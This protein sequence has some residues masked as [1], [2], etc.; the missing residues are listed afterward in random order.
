M[1]KQPGKCYNKIVHEVVIRH[2]VGGG[3][4]SVGRGRNHVSFIFGIQSRFISCID[5]QRSRNAST[6]KG[7]CLGE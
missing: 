2:K 7:L 3:I 1:N 6:E 5:E 4:F